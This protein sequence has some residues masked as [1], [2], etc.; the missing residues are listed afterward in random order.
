M[1]TR[2]S[3]DATTKGESEFIHFED[4][5][6][7]HPFVE[8]VWRCR[9]ERAGSFLSVAANNFEMTMTRLGRKSLLTLRG[10]EI[11]W[12][13]AVCGCETFASGT[14][15]HIDVDGAKAESETRSEVSVHRCDRPL[16]IEGTFTGDWFLA[17]GP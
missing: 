15:C 13:G 8:N 3:L 2:A 10:P 16:P 1:S 6:S 12:Y 7:D 5:T 11:A 9:S 17:A 4:R 14:S